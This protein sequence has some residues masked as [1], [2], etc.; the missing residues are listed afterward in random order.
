MLNIPTFPRVALLIDADNI[1]LDHLPQILKIANWYGSLKI[2]CAYGDWERPPLFAYRDEVDKLN[3]LRV[4]VPRI[5]KDTTD[6][7]LMIE[8]GT[9]LGAD[10]ADL[11]IIASGDAD[12]TQLCESI[13]REGRKAVGIGNK[14]QTSPRL[15]ASCDDFHYV[16]DLD[17]ILR[18]LEQTPLQGEFAALL[19]RA[20]GSLSTDKE[21]WV[22]LTPL[23][24]KLRELDPEFDNRF[25]GRKLST[26]VRGLDGLFDIKGQ[27][28]RASIR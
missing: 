13:R 4:P 17:K 16:E 24:K 28:I 9:I 22:S 23:G 25:G 6:K 20:L 18:Q 5:G 1:Q 7:Q 11:F 19:F 26:W 3:I 2:C 10:R 8:A 15:L 21:G 12:F 27:M 14:G